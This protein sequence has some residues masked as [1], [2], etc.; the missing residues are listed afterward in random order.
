[1]RACKCELCGSKDFNIVRL[2][3]SAL[4]GL[5]SG[6]TK[7]MLQCSNPLCD[8]CIFDVELTF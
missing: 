5:E 3:D 6:T 4:T 1:M 7:V 2:D 8:Y